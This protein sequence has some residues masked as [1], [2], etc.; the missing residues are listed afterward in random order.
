MPRINYFVPC[1]IEGCNK[2]MIALGLCRMHYYRK[3][4]TGTIEHR[5]SPGPVDR[6]WKFVDRNGPIHLV[7]GQCW[8]W[9]GGKFRRGYGAF[10]AK[11]KQL[12]A[13]RFSWELHYGAIPDELRVCHHC[14]NTACV[15]PAHLFLG[16]DADN[17]ADRDKKERQARGEQQRHARLTAEQVRDIRRRYVKNSAMNGSTA[18]AIE[19]GVSHHAIL[20]IISRQ[21]WKHI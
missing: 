15:N 16:T 2:P 19:F 20:C 17:V 11:G 13:H 7:H 21:T 18:L 14:D 5:P 9:T 1:D 3:K 8:V 4:R 12:K 10:H 6:F